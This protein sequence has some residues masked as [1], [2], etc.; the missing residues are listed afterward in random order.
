MRKK[1]SGGHLRRL[2]AKRRVKMQNLANLARVWVEVNN[3]LIDQILGRSDLPDT[4]EPYHPVQLNQVLQRCCVSESEQLRGFHSFGSI[5]QRT[6]K[7][8]QHHCPL[9]R[10]QPGDKAFKLWSVQPI[11]TCFR[12]YFDDHQSLYRLLGFQLPQF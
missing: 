1:T 10:M 11:A 6:T 8:Q 2:A 5:A 7:H 9:R 4:R 3:Q 12:P